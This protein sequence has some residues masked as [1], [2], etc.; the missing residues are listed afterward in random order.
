MIGI[1]VLI[2]LH[3]RHLRLHHLLLCLDKG[4]EIEKYLQR[5]DK[6]DRGGKGVP[7]QILDQE[8]KLLL[9]GVNLETIE[10]RGKE[11]DNH[12]INIKEIVRLRDKGKLK[13][14]GK[15]KF[16]WKIKGKNRERLNLKGKNSYKFK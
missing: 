14:I 7:I 12:L 1:A 10:I 13:E 8:V 2:H 3:R 15:E 16:N 5:I 4:T 11:K 6:G 9:K